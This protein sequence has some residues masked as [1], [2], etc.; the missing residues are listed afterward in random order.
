MQLMPKGAQQFGAFG[1]CY[2]VTRELPDIEVE[3][4]QVADFVD[5]AGGQLCPN[6][7][8]SL[9]PGDVLAP[10]LGRQSEGSGGRSVPLAALRRIAHPSH[11]LRRRSE[12]RRVGKE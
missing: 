2:R 12:E 4:D 1:I 3:R 7:K 5:P 10:C 6:L 11:D 8:A 9:A